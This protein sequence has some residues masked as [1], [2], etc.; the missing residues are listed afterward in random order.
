MSIFLVALCKT[1]N[2]QIPVRERRS[3]LFRREQAEDI[4]PAIGGAFT[5]HCCG[6]RENYST[7][8]LVPC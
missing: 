1:S 4:V 8:T 3:V 2:E 6:L 7:G 5:K